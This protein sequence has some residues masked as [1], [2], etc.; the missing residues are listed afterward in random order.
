MTNV[1]VFYQAEGLT[2]I[3]HVELPGDA[4]LAVVKTQIAGRH[5]LGEEV[6]IFVEDEE[7][8]ARESILLI[9]IATHVGVKIHVHHCEHIKTSVFFNGETVEHKFTPGTTVAR[10]K[11][12]AAVHKFGMSAEE[13]GEHVLQISGTKDRPA[14]NTHLGALTDRHHCKVSFD[15]VPDERVNGCSEGH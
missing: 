8:P 9:E 1:N 4:T 6:L 11:H 10:V 2:A 15:L 12:W 3:E 14:P 5:G 7:T 13:A